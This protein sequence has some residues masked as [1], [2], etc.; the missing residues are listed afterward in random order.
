MATLTESTP[1]GPRRFHLFGID[2]NNDEVR[3]HNKQVKFATGGLAALAL[4]HNSRFEY[5]GSGNQTI[6][7]LKYYVE[8]LLAFWFAKKNR[9]HR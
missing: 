9:Q 2:C 7:G 4:K 1:G 3:P 5:T 8:K 6:A